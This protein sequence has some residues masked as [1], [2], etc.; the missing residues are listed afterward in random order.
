MLCIAFTVNIFASTC[1]TQGI[2]FTRLLVS[3]PNKLDFYVKTSFKAIFWLRAL[4]T[5]FKAYG[6]LQ[7]VSMCDAWMAYDRGEQEPSH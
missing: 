5:G 3:M 7:N 6:D 1:V 4:L 2:L